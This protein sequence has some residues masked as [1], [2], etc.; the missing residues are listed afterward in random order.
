[1]LDRE[2]FIFIPFDV[3]SPAK[4]AKNPGIIGKIHGERNDTKPAMSAIPIGIL[5]MLFNKIL[6]FYFT[7]NEPDDLGHYHDAKREYKPWVQCVSNFLE[8]NAY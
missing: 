6:K 8:N 7:I 3:D 5:V 2:G 1:M 4:Y